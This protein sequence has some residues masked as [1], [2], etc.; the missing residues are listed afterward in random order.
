MKNF[1]LG[2]RDLEAF[3]RVEYE[4]MA[5]QIMTCRSD[6]NNQEKVEKEETEVD[7]KLMLKVGSSCFLTF[8]ARE[9][10]YNVHVHVCKY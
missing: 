9:Y 7:I 8:H 3:I 4:S 2:S 5:K 6:G 1:G 10:M